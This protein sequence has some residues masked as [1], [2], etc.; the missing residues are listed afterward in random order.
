MDPESRG[1]FINDSKPIAWPND[2]C[3]PNKQGYSQLARSAIIVYNNWV[4]TILT[5]YL[6]LLLSCRTVYREL[7]NTHFIA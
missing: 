3:H 7:V 6:V 5:R 4:A 1:L 2:G